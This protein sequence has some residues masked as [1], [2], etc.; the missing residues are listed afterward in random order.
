[1][2]AKRWWPRIRGRAGRD[3][4]VEN[5]A[6]E[7]AFGSQVSAALAGEAT[8]LLGEGAAGG[9]DFEA[10]GLDGTGVPMCRAETAGR[11]GKQADGG[12]KTREAKLVTVWSAEGQARHGMPGR[13]PDSVSCN[14]AVEGI[15]T[16]DT[17]RAPAPF[18]ARSARTRLPM[19]RRPSAG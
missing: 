6:V 18:A 7:A 12:A 2:P 16:R 19:R 14:A 9:C 11:V 15:A 17:G 10:M 3:G 13:D 8:R 4:T 5:R 1:M